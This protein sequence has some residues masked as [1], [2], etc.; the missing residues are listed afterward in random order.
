MF[1]LAAFLSGALTSVFGWITTYFGVRAATITAMVGAYVVATAA[2]YACLNGFFALLDVFAGFG[3]EG[4]CAQ[5]HGACDWISMAFWSLWPSN[6]NTV[7]AI[8]I[9]ADA[10]VFLWRYK[11][12]LLAAISRA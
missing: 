2:A 4:G 10:C 1:R 8:C 9:G 3:S 5:A 6:A 11:L 12:G 7:I